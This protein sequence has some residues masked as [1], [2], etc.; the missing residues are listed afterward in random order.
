MGGGSRELICGERQI[1]VLQIEQAAGKWSQ[2][3]EIRK[4]KEMAD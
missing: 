1:L 2:R 3:Q 4:W